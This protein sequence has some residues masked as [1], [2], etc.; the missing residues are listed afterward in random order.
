MAVN[1]N[2]AQFVRSAAKLADFPRD[3]FPQVVFAG[4]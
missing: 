3:G 4:R 1:W 2:I